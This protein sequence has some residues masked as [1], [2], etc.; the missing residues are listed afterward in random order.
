MAILWLS[1]VHGLKQLQ[2]RMPT[3]LE[4]DNEDYF[5]DVATDGALDME[6]PEEF[7]EQL[8]VNVLSRENSSQ[9]EVTLT[10]DRPLEATGERELLHILIEVYPTGNQPFPEDV[11]F[12]FPFIDGTI[13]MEGRGQAAIPHVT[14]DGSLLVNPAG[15]L[16]APPVFQKEQT[17][18]FSKRSE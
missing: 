15:S 13:L 9:W 14:E 8:S 3:T 2:F 7:S 17:E 10:C 18:L 6:I 5:I 4:G 16:E 12:P 11:L 1:E